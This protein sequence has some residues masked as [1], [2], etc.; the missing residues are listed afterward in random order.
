MSHWAQ[1]LTTGARGRFDAAREGF[2]PDGAGRGGARG[3][4]AAGIVVVVLFFGV[5]GG[6]AVLSQLRS[7]VVAEAVFQAAGNRRALQHREGGIVRQVLARDGDR[8]EKGQV[9]MRLDDTVARTTVE[10]LAVERDALAVLRVRLV[11][12]RDD[13]DHITLDPDLVA[14]ASE[15]VLGRLIAAQAAQFD[16]R[17]R[18]QAGQLAMLDR[19]AGQQRDQSRGLAAQATGLDQQAALTEEEARG[20]RK[21]Y[22]DGYAARNRVLAYARTQAGLVADRGRLAAQV[23]SLE[24]AIAETGLRMVQLRRDRMAQVADQLRQTEQQLA[25]IEPRLLSA[26]ETLD[27]TVMR[28]TASGV[29]LGLNVFTEGGVIAAGQKVLEIVPDDGEPELEARLPPSDAEKV[30]RGQTVE[31]QLTGMPIARRPLISGHVET[32]SADRLSDDHTGA[33]Y[34]A[35]RVKIDQVKPGPGADPS[36]PLVHIGAGMPAQMIVVTGSRS[37]FEYLVGPLTDQIR[38]ALREE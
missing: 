37:A 5:I 2:Q 3:L 28:A 38:H 21:L 1:E 4:I 14:R 8:V 33:A 36:A 9:L 13:A 22:A 18:Q 31:V 12:E 16:E 7:A 19:E 27:R 35:V 20:V 24:G 6:W 26:R 29:V 10:S 11:A 34:Y 23:A 32:V 15:K 17:R 25:E 30:H